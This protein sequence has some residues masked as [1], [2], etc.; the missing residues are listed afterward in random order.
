[1]VKN[2][3]KI[4]AHLKKINR[5][6]NHLCNTSQLAISDQYKKIIVYLAYF[7]EPT[8]DLPFSTILS[9]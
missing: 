7:Y 4:K 8:L 5:F 6:L 3:R 2:N 9:Q 1:M